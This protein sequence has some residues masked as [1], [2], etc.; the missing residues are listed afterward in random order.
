MAVHAAAPRWLAERPASVNRRVMMMSFRILL[1]L[2]KACLGNG[3]TPRAFR[4]GSPIRQISVIRH[5]LRCG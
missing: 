5:L 2:E 4:D 1:S 3:F